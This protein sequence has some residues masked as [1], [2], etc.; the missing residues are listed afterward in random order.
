MLTETF[1]LSTNHEHGEEEHNHLFHMHHPA[2][3]FHG[4]HA[5]VGCEAP[6]SLQRLS[7]VKHTTSHQ[8]ISMDTAPP[9]VPELSPKPRYQENLTQPGCGEEDE[10]A[11]L[12]LITQ[13][14]GETHDLLLD[15]TQDA[16]LQERFFRCV[17]F[18]P[19]T[20]ISL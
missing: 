13:H 5:G 1:N 2:L 6:A 20:Q 17:S 4:H 18:M 12:V 11:G 10:D 9:S 7:K 15:L 14:R 3:H 8:A 19:R 16:S